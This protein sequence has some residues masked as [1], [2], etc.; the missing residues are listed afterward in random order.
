MACWTIARHFLGCTFGK[1]GQ[2]ARLAK[3]TRNL[4]YT[5]GVPVWQGALV[6]TLAVDDG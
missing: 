1:Y 6:S 3:R 5:G 4:K 2:E